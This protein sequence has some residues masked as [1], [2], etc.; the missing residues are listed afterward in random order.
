[1]TSAGNHA[2]DASDNAAKAVTI[3]EEVLK[4]QSIAFALVHASVQFSGS[5]EMTL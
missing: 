4:K 3:Y 5:L 2:Q 1:V